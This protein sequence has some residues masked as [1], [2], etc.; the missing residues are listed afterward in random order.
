MTTTEIMRVKY[1][2]QGWHIVGPQYTAAI[3]A[4]VL[5][6]GGG[7]LRCPFCSYPLPAQEMVIVTQASGTICSPCS[8]LTQEPPVSGLDHPKNGPPRQDV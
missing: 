6:E 8:V 4:T 5:R 7:G 1:S 2:V 3:M